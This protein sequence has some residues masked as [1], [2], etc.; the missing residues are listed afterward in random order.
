MCEISVGYLAALQ[1]K[2]FEVEK[3]EEIQTDNN[4]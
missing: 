2:M 1:L 4:F 3:S